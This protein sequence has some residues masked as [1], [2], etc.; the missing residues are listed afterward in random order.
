MRSDWVTGDRCRGIETYHGLEGLNTRNLR[1]KTPTPSD[2][3]HPNRLQPSTE[4]LN[5][6]SI[7]GL[8]LSL[9][10]LAMGPTGADAVVVQLFVDKFCPAENPGPV[11]TDVGER[12]CCKDHV[13]DIAVR[14]LKF[15]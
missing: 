14:A 13:G 3:P 10:A 7:S 1:R 11:C 15:S 4:M 2:N 9:V 6:F 5:L 12:Q 8:A